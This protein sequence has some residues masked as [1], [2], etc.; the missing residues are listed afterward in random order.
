M[1]IQIDEGLSFHPSAFKCQNMWIK[2]KTPT[3]S[4]FESLRGICLLGILLFTSFFRDVRAS[5]KIKQH[6]PIWNKDF[7]DNITSLIM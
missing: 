3:S 7:F 2:E 4:K 6:I 1:L 5:N